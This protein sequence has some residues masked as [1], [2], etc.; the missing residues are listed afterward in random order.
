MIGQKGAGCALTASRRAALQIG[1]APSC[2]YIFGRLECTSRPG[3]RVRQHNTVTAHWHRA[4]VTDQTERH[5]TEGTRTETE[6]PGRRPARGPTVGSSETP[7]A[8]AAARPGGRAAP[9]GCRRRWRRR[10]GASPPCRAVPRSAGSRP[11]DRDHWHV[12]EGPAWTQHTG[13]GAQP[14]RVATGP[15]ATRRG[16]SGPAAPR[17]YP[18]AELPRRRSRPAARAGPAKPRPGPAVRRADSAKWGVYIYAKYAE[19]RL[20]TILHIQN[21]FAYFL[22]YFL[23]IL[24]IILHILCHTIQ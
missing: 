1:K 21:G 20:V 18:Q 10:L 15:S 7:P 9:R 23:H 19:Y 13:R 14:C 4:S 11:G 24:H 22:T 16:S 12:R 5:S 6:G 8:A 3:P 17:Q 2:L